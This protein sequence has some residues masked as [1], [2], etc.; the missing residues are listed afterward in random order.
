MPR[1][2]DAQSVA[3]P[4]TALYWHIGATTI[5]L[6]RVSP[7]GWSG[8]NNLLGMMVETGGWRADGRRQTAD[9][10]RQT[11]DGRRAKRGG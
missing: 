6:S 11:A 4:S 7:A 8:E 2:A 9:G 10:R 3:Q 1:W 5:R